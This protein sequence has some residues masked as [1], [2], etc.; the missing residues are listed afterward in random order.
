MRRRRPAA[1]ASTSS[2]ATAATGSAAPSPA[3]IAKD[4]FA[5]DNYTGTDVQQRGLAAPSTIKGNGEFNPGVGGPIK[6][7][8]LWFFV[9]GKYVFADNFVA[10]MFFNENANNPNEFR[11]V[12]S[13]RQAILHQDQQIFQ[14]RLTYQ[15]NQKNKFGVTFDQEAYCGCPVRHDRDRLA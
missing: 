1:C 6:S 14:A 5:A 2:R 13:T 7:D 8:K 12:R 11:Y 3:A 4:S 10:G 15:A 9:S